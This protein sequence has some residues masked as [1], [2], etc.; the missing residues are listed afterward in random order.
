MA[1]RSHA[2]SFI[3]ELQ[4]V[5]IPK[6]NQILE[7]RLDA[8]RQLYNSC[9]GEAMRHLSVMRSSQEWQAARTMPKSKERT[10][11][12]K[13]LRKQYNY[14]EYALHAFAGRTRNACWIGDHIDSLTAQKVATRAFKAVEDYEF[15]RHG[16]PRFKRKGWMSSLEGKNNIAGIRWC[17]DHVEW[18]GLSLK[19][20]FDRK[21]RY[22]IQAHALSHDVKYVRL[23]KKV[24]RGNSCWFAQ[25]VLKGTAKIKANHAIGAETVGLDIGPST[26]AV[27]SDT[28]AK[29]LEFCPDIEIPYRKIRTIQRQLDRSRR[30]TNPG[31]YNLDGTIKP[32]KK[33]WVFSTR[34]L[35]LKAELAETQRI[36]VEKRKRAHNALAHSVLS[37]GTDIR[38]EKLSYKGLQRRYGKSISRRAPG[39]FIATL[40]RKAENAGGQVTEF[41]TRSTKL[42][43]TCHCG[44]QAKKTL[45]NRWHICTCGVTVQR[46]MYSAFLAKYVSNDVLDTRQAELAWPGANQLLERAVS[47]L[48]HEAANGRNLPSSFGISRRQSCSPVKDGSTAVE[49]DNVNTVAGEA[50]GT[51]VRTPWL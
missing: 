23:V 41:P 48:K 16:K 34:Y 37:L 40:R 42:S 44:T 7:I 47:G 49:A 3:H 19:P 35:T 25:L 36:L 51:V 31:N 6:D 43:Q 18:S 26:I 45:N 38:T 13:A 15:Q 30:S 2:P 39:G 4:L 21:D 28:D 11:K 1:K 27:V 20:L 46:D 17:N 9:L 50:A 12:F 32:G 29:L 8:G 14:S 24:I 10:T 33:Q 5:T 22:G